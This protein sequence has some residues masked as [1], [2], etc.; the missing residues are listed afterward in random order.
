MPCSPPPNPAAAASS[1]TASAPP[2]RGRSCLSRRSSF[3]D[4]SMESGRRASMTRSIFIVL[5]ATG[6][7]GCGVSEELYNARVAELTKAKSDLDGERRA[8]SD[9]RKQLD[10]LN[11][12]KANLESRLGALGKKESDLVEAQKRILEL[13]KA[14]E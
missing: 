4:S 2:K 9:A 6:L 8:N 5:V 3:H 10:E 13:Q 14:Q 7:A 12:Q 1:R 11:A